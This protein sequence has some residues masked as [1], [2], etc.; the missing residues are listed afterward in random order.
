SHRE[1]AC[2]S[3]NRI[4]IRLWIYESCIRLESLSRD[5][6]GYKG[7]RFNLYE[8]V[9]SMPTIKTDPLGRRGIVVACCSVCVGTVTYIAADCADVCQ[10][11]P[12]GG[13]AW[14]NC[15]TDCV[16]IY[17]TAI[18]NDPAA[19]FAITVACGAGCGKLVVDKLC[20][21][22]APL[23]CRQL[24]Q[25]ILQQAGGGGLLN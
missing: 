11:W 1:S 8:Y 10:Q 13:N 6:V 15:Y 20:F 7:S 5:P 3:F 12:I 14:K 18:L 4:E 25:W 9:D 16:K 2:K 17:L 24:Q 22:L 23:A 21:Q 19:V